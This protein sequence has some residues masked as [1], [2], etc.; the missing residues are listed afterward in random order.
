MV[1]TRRHGVD[2]NPGSGTYAIRWSGASSIAKGHLV[3]RRCASVS[4]VAS[5]VAAR[6]IKRIGQIVMSIVGLAVY[7]FTI[8]DWF[9]TT[10]WYDDWLGT[11]A[12]GL[13]GLLVVILPVKPLPTTTSDT[14]T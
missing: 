6:K 3:N 11:L 12:L 5:W 7:V 14:A 10:T 9:A 1:P 2:L 8:G 13:F 4:G